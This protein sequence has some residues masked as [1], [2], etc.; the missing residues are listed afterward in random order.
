MKGFLKSLIDAEIHLER[1]RFNNSLRRNFIISDAFKALDLN[2]K[3]SINIEDIRNFMT[4]RH[5]FYQD[6]EIQYLFDRIDKMKCG[7]INLNEFTRELRP[8]LI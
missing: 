8:K 3:D 6:Y 5:I 7:E 4:A 1:L 2:S